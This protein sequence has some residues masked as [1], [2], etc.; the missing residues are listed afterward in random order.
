MINIHSYSASQANFRSLTTA[1]Q[2]AG[3]GLKTL[4]EPAK[5][6]SSLQDSGALSA[7]ARE[8]PGMEA[9]EFNNLDAS[10]YTP[11]KIADRIGQF[12]ALGLENA[13]AQGKSEEEV[14]SL[15]D[16]AMKGLEQGFK[17]A[18]EILKNLDLLG[19]GIGEQVKATEDATFAALEKLSPANQSQGVTGTATLGIA[20]AQRYQ[21]A[22]DFELSLQTKD[23][24]TVKISFSRD[25]AAQQSNATV[26]D[27]QGNQVSLM[28]VSQSES[29]GYQ[30]KV[31]GNLSVE[32]IDAIQKLVE[33]VGKVANDFFR[34]DVEKAFAQV[35]DVSF[36]DS[37]LA[38]MN[39]RMS[40]TEQYSAVQQYQQTQQLENP[41]QAQSGRRLGHL[42]R[43]MSDSFQNPALEFLSQA[44][45]AASQIMRGLVEQDSRFQEA[46]PERQSRYQSDMERFLKAVAEPSA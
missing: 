7:L 6:L 43:E 44:R 46:S 1:S 30:F 27:E 18:K 35:S 20:S 10:E 26:M 16:S 5:A 22:E 34:G 37:Q 14:Q 9:S 42:M 21:R 33:D 23:G 29:S 15:Y 12:V 19:G 24:D 3:Q 45:E 8:I 11:D 25:F 2:G 32:E 17:E 39:L 38:S 4:N 41:E 31:E 28:D 40:R 13:R 36:D